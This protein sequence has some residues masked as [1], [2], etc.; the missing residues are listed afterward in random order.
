M[1]LLYEN[2]KL[3]INNKFNN[4]N[5]EEY[6]K[7]VF[8]K[9]KEKFNLELNSIYLVHIYEDVND[10]IMEIKYEEENY[11]DEVEMKIIYEHTNILYQIDDIFIDE[12]ILKNSIIIS[13]NKKLYLKVNKI[14]DIDLAYLHEI[15][16]II[17]KNTENIIKYGRE[18]RLNLI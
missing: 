18:L 11:Y 15:S 2:Y 1:Y 3:Y 12:K 13:Y 9:I 10:I 8:L 6:F 5:I 4:K 7:E 16:K 14:L 17:Y